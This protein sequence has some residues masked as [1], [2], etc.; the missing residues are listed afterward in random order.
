M[1]RGGD[2]EMPDAG[3]VEV[4]DVG[5]GLPPVNEDAADEV[6]ADHIRAEQP[7]EQEVHS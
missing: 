3:T 6:L 2:P 1:S 7:A 4:L 5:D